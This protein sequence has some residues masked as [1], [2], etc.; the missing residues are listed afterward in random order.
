MAHVQLFLH[1]LTEG[2][3]DCFQVWAILKK[4]AMII[5]TQV[6]VCQELPD[7][8]GHPSP[9]RVMASYG[10][11]RLV[12]FVKNHPISFQSGCVPCCTP[13]L[14]FEVTSVLDLGH[15][16]RGEMMPMS[17]ITFSFFF[18]FPLFLFLDHTWQYSGCSWQNDQ[19]L[20]LVMLWGPY[21]AW[22]QTRAS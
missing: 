6:S 2:Q 16:S 11:S 5:C 12:W 15:S 4:T 21:C 9:R 3:I 14:A 17:C 19:R 20:Y 10:K 22:D 8:L 18:F 13:S 1:P 7:S